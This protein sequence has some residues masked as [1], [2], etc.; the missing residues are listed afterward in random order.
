MKA[1]ELKIKSVFR[2]LDRIEEYVQTLGTLPRINDVLDYWQIAKDLCKKDGGYLA[3]MEELAKIAN[4]IYNTNVFGAKVDN[5]SLGSGAYD[6]TKASELGLPSSAGFGV[7]SS[8][9]YPSHAGH[10]YTRRFCDNGSEWNYYNR[11]SSS[12][13]AVCLGD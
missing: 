11:Y 7:W 12:Y 13:W 1:K 4:Y 8:E 5:Y 6:S 9:E 10:A 3:S 2:P